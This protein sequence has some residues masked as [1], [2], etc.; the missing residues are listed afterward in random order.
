MSSARTRRPATASLHD[1][2]V[3]R[4]LPAHQYMDRATVN[5]IAQNR[6]TPALAPVAFTLP[7]PGRRFVPES[8]WFADARLADSIHGIRHQ[9]R[10]CLLADL[11]AQHHQLSPDDAAALCL[12]AA[13]HDCRRHDDRDD[14]GHGQR[15]AS[16]LKR[17][18]DTVLT[19]F[20]K[21]LPTYSRDQAAAVGLHDVPHET[22][23]PSQRRAYQQ[24]PHLVD[25]LKA[26][27]ALDRY[28]L[29]LQHWWP[30]LS[31]L[32]ATVP[33]WLPTV[34]FEL[35][36]RSE[37]ARLNGA[38][39]RQALDDACQLFTTPPKGARL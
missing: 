18:S 36:V 8:T 2:A 26:A 22:F 24:A 5:W 15:T 4:S 31:R 16:W 21:E 39:H 10:V 35:V 30:D 38:T 25:L 27:D 14:S 34:A 3:Q 33:D 11:L 32:R 28:R 6:P 1:R 12:A 17:H 9:A 7:Q 13:V 19:T 20:G 29:P 23:T 37:Q